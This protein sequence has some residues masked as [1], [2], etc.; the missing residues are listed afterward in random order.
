MKEIRVW[1]KGEMITDGNRSTLRKSRS[2]S[3]LEDIRLM[4]LY[5]QNDTIRLYEIFLRFFARTLL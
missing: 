5:R 2:I 1:S 4:F 3:T